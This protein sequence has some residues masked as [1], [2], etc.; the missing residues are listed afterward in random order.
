MRGRGTGRGGMAQRL[1]GRGPAGLHS[2]G[3]PPHYLAHTLRTVPHRKRTRGT[4]RRRLPGPCDA[5]CT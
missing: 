5:L 1:W 2:H 4:Q 3:Q